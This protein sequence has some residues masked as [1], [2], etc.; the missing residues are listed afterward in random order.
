MQS[1]QFSVS[2]TLSEYLRFIQD[3]AAIVM[4]EE[5]AAR[6]KLPKT[7]VPFV[8]RFF[9]GAF[10]SG[11]FFF[12]KRRMPVCEFT[13]DEDHITR[14]TADGKVIVPWRDVN[15]IHRYRNGYLVAK[16]EGAMPLPLRC[17]TP[18]QASVLEALIERREHELQQTV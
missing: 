13:I 10:A 6:G 3:H 9:V 12:K 1:I 4:N 17:L 5:L 8:V 2:Y 7:K 15:A 14:I 18:D 11:M 16:I